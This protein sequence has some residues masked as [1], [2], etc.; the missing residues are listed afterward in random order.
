MKG[1]PI[2]TEEFERLLAAVDKAV[3][4][5]AADSWKLL[6]RG[7]WATGLRPSEA[8]ALRWDYQPDGVHVVLDGK[9]SVLAFDAESQKSGRVEQTPLAPEAVQLLEPLE[10]ASG[11][12][13]TP[14]RPDCTVINRATAKRNYVTNFVGK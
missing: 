13:F 6:L 14:I 9:H 3:R 11:W 8:L 5:E 2:T 4:P 10:R 7:L 12:V 1:R